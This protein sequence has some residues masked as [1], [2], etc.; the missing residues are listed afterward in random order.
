M[1][2]SDDHQ[3]PP[4]ETCLGPDGGEEE[5]YG[6]ASVGAMSLDDEDSGVA[7]EAAKVADK[8]LTDNN[9]EIGYYIKKGTEFVPMTNFSVQCIGYV[10]ESSTSSSTEGFLFRVIPKSFSTGEI[11][12]ANDLSRYAKILYIVS[13][14]RRSFVFVMHCTLPRGGILQCAQVLGKEAGKTA[15]AY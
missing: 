6:G 11:A 14:C 5:T 7:Q 10:M 4:L 3:H 15:H 8:Q 2:L 13:I 1:P 12:T 9:G